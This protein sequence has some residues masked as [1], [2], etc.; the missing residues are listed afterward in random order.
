MQ[1]D[2]LI[3]VPSNV[4]PRTMPDYAALAAQGTYSLDGGVRVFAGQ[5]QD[6]FAIDLGGVFDTLNFRVNPPLLTAAQDADDTVN[7][8]GIDQ[9]SGFN[10]HS[11][12][13]ELPMDVLKAAG[14]NASD[15][16]GAYASTSRS[17]V[18]VRGRGLSG[19]AQVQRLANPLVNEVVIGTKDK[20]AWNATDPSNEGAFLDY[21][22]KPRLA[23]A[24][25][26]LY[27]AGSTGCTPFGTA[28]CSPT[29]RDDLVN[30]LLKY[31]PT[32]PHLSELLRLNLG[33]APTPLASQRRL[34]FLAG[35]NAGWPNG[36]RPKDDVTDIAVRAVGGPFYI[37]NRAGD[38]VNVDDAALM[39]AFPYLALP[40][41]G[42]DLK[43]GGTQTPHKAPPA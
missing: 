43:S 13:I 42:R 3:A 26:L 21:Y 32:D 39:N 17:R 25:E 6:P 34:S 40:A 28:A 8:F 15:V 37:T 18:T 12:A 30:I 36:R 10:V 5:R 9:L 4:G 14:A 20:D 2:G 24:L 41:D 1:K 19:F 16:I 35:D 27:G 29:N 31:D 11:I 38:G 22:L 7:P 33:V 23:T